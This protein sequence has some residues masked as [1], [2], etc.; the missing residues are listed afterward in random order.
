MEYD[1]YGIY[2]D[3]EIPAEPLMDVDTNSGSNSVG[4]GILCS[5]PVRLELV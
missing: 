2:G 4:R 5:H 3:L 1:F